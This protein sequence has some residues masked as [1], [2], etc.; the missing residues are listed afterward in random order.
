MGSGS[1]GRD[2]MVV[3]L[4]TTYAISA[5]QAI[6]TN[7]VSLNPAQV[8]CT[9]YNFVS[10]LRRVCGFFWVLLFPPPIKQSHDI[11]EI[12]LKVTLIP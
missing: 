11:T 7:V 3:G 12:L 1:R 2:R 6:A 9:R 4:P 10:Y 5:Y 8:R